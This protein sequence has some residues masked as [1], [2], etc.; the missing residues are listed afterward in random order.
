MKRRLLTC[1]ACAV[2]LLAIGPAASAKP[3]PD[4]GT[5]G[6]SNPTKVCNALKKADKA[7]FQAVWGKHAMRDCKRSH[8]GTTT[9]PAEAAEA[10]HNAAQ[11][12]RAERAA[13]PAA[14]T[15]TYGTNHNGRNAF[16]K[17]VSSHANGTY[18]EAPPVA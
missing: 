8:R 16:G 3:K 9:P 6:S 10:F 4:D 14:F 2:V 15:A 12:C 17:C 1:A 7:A 11:Q 5:D 18:Q 13:D